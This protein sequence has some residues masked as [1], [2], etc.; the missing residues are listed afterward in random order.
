MAAVDYFLKIDGIKGESQDKTHKDEVDVF[1]F[2]W[3]MSQQGTGGKGGGGGAGKVAFHDFK[4]TKEVDLSTPKLWDA[5]A[6]GKHIASAVL[7]CRKAGGSP[8]EYWTITLTDVLV[9]SVLQHPPT[10]EY[11]EESNQAKGNTG[12]LVATETVTFNFAAYEAN[13]KQQQKDGTAGGAVT[14]KFNVKTNAAG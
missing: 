6:T 5:C 1:S 3:G 11:G 4:V 13:Y 8:I 10:F 14:S 9:S 12:N 2:S 7:T